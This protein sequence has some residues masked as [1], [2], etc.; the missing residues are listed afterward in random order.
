MQRELPKIRSG[1]PLAE[2]PRE[3]PT[4]S[5]GQI[6]KELATK[7]WSWREITGLVGILLG[8]TIAIIGYA[9][10]QLIIS[11]ILLLFVLQSIIIGIFN[12][13]RMASLR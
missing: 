11:E 1:V 6:A 13:A 8:N 9:T 10:G 4:L 2:Q 12:A 5:A 3:R 7:P